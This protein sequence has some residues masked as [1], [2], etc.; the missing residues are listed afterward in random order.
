MSLYSQN[1][2]SDDPIDILLVEDTKSDARLIQEAFEEIDQETTIQ[3]I[4]DGDEAID[5]LTQKAADGSLPDFVFVDLNPPERAGRNVLKTI[6]ADPDLHCLPVIMLLHPESEG[7]IV[8]YYHAHANACLRKPTDSAEFISL[9]ETIKR[10]WFDQV[11]LPP[12]SA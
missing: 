4:T 7:D 9:A 3:T 1:Q 10:F 12:V 5:V 2:K 8:Q 11:H 6:K